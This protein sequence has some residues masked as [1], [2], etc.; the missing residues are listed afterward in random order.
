MKVRKVEKS[1]SKSKAGWI[2]CQQCAHDMFS[3]ILNLWMKLQ[4]I[5]TKF[6]LGRNFDWD[7]NRKKN[8]NF[9]VQT[10]WEAHKIWKNLPHDLDVY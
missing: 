7:Q 1:N 2:Q 9:E 5:F 4:I 10:F 6:S 3:R 8:V